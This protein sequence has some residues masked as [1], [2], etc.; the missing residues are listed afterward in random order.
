VPARP[1]ARRARSLKQLAGAD[2]AI[3]AVDYN[4]EDDIARLFEGHGLAAP[5]SCCA[6]ARR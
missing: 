3:T 1:S 5:G 2:W 6:R 4:A